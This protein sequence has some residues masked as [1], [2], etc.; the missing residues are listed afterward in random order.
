MDKLLEITAAQVSGHLILRCGIFTAMN[1]SVDARSVA[2]SEKTHKYNCAHKVQF[3]TSGSWWV[4]GRAMVAES[5]YSY[6][7]NHRISCLLVLH[8]TCLNICKVLVPCDY[9]L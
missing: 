5:V 8:Y 2:R 4:F 7:S 1:H 9:V 3:V 6:Y